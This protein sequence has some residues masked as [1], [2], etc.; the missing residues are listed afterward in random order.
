ML[1]TSLWFLVQF[2]CVAFALSFGFSPA[3]W[4][5]S[6]LVWNEYSCI[7]TTRVTAGMNNALRKKRKVKAYED[8]GNNSFIHV[9]H[10]VK[11]I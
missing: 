11:D 8:G 3:S 2:L 10:L 4:L 5:T 6:V 1:H 7:L 9:R